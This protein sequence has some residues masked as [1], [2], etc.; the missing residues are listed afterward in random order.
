MTLCGSVRAEGWVKRGLRMRS[1]TY[2]LFF[3]PIILSLIVF[4]AHAVER[5]QLNSLEGAI[6]IV[7][8]TTIARRF[9]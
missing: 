7:L 2:T 5:A 6:H 1:K 8:N 3:W 9:F 4:V